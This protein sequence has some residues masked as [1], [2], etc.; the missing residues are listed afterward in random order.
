M[1]R[2]FTLLEVLVCLALFAL[3]VGL[4]LPAVQRVRE[5]ANRTRC[6][7]NLRQLGLACH[8]YHDT[9]HA[10]PPS[11]LDCHA[12]TWCNA[13]LPYLE[14]GNGAAIWVQGRAYH[15]QPEAARHLRVVGYTCPS[16]PDRGASR[17]GDGRGVVPHRSGATGDYA[18]VIGNGT[19]GHLDHH[20][21]LAASLGLR[22]GIGPFVHAQ[23]ARCW[24]K[25]PDFRHSD[26]AARLF[27]TL[28]NLDPPGLAYTPLIGEKAIKPPHADTAIFNPD[29]PLANG[30][31][32]P[33][34][35][36]GPHPGVTLY[37]F[38]DGSAHPMKE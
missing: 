20:P 23:A 9:R 32:Y 31:M 17:G 26:P 29:N 36:A 33:A 34:G 24:G 38:A 1:R 8:H 13:L 7:S 11:R 4:F 15:F 6:L 21:A 3:L 10:L 28:A 27:V 5:A 18:A 37:V 14:Q 22:P 16:R 19:P 35:F 12:G 25:D 30:R 2:A